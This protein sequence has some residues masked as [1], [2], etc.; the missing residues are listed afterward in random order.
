MAGAV[1]VVDREAR[2]YRT[3]R[4]HRA[5]LRQAGM[6]GLLV[7]ADRFDPD[8]GVPFR[9]YAQLWVRKEIQRAIAEQEFAATVPATLVGP[10]VALRALAPDGL[11]VAAAALDLSV[12]TVTALYRQLPTATDPDEEPE[13]RG[14]PGFPDPEQTAV[15]SSMTTLLQQAMAA[16]DDRTARAFTLYAETG[17]F[18]AVGRQ[19]GCSDHTARTLVGKARARLRAAVIT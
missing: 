8:R 16:L 5:D 13:D 14:L 7:A 18:R 17:S 6:V 15:A 9:A 4:L 11:T 10:L 2:R 1:D 19:L 3:W 12:A